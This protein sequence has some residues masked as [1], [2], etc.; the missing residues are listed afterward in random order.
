MFTPEQLAKIM[1]CSDTVALAWCAPLRSAMTRGNITTARRAAHFLAQV[2]H[3]SAS[4]TRLE[5]NL[6]YSAQRLQDVW[7]SR[8]TRTTAL[9]Y[10]RKPERIANRV[11]A[12]RMGN[13]DEASGDGWRYRGR[14][15]IQLTGRNNYRHM[16]DLTGLPLVEKP[17]IAR[18]AAEGAVIACT[19]W[20]ANGLNTL[21]DRDDVLAVSRRVNLGTTNT[22]R[23]PQ[24]LQD[25]IARTHRAA[26]VLGVV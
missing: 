13:G 21:A 11:Y 15:P 23:T 8:F 6:N 4:L 14:S 18:G 3:E 26:Q 12:L 16:A 10:A 22:Q 5:E 1:G 24:G 7:P 2:G 25:R 17:D 9:E 20:Q 19:W